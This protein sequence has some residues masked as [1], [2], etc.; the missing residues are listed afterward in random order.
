MLASKLL[1]ATRSLSPPIAGISFTQNADNGTTLVVNRPF[2]AKSGDLLI[3]FLMNSG[4]ATGST[5]TATGW[6]EMLDRGAVPNMAIMRKTVGAGEAE[7]YTFT[8]SNATQR[9]LGLILC[10]RNYVYD[11][12]GTVATAANP[13]V[14]SG[15][16]AATANS[17]LIG[18]FCNSL[19]SI[20]C[21]TPTNMTRAFIE[22]DSVAP[23]IAVFIQTVG[24]GATGSRSSSCGT[25]GARGGVLLALNPV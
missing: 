17:L 23:S 15:I 10:F 9:Q 1:G 3:A 21:T 2:T 16:S 14:A 24:S 4:G 22:S 5:Y 7:T 19:G 12:I 20:A 25:T 8:N 6:T 18:Y 11:K 13:I